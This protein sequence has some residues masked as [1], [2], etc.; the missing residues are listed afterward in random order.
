MAFAGCTEWLPPDIKFHHA[1]AWG[2]QLADDD[3]AQ[4]LPTPYGALER[5]QFTDA[6]GSTRRFEEQW[7]ARPS[8]SGCEAAAC[9]ENDEITAVR[10]LID[11][12]AVL[13]SPA[14]AGFF[15]KRRGCWHLERSLGSKAAVQAL[16]DASAPW[17]VLTD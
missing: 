17:S 4:W 16:F 8:L 2:G 6:T 12:Q 3:Q 10:V 13:V 11:S 7:I 9:V 1:V 15:R 14:H 5:G